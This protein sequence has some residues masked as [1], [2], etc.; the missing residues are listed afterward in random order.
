PIPK[1]ARACGGLE[2]TSESMR[3]LASLCFL[4]CFLP[5]KFAA[6]HDPECGELQNQ[7][8]MSLVDRSG[9]GDSQHRGD[10]QHQEHG[11]RDLV[12][13]PH[14]GVEHGLGPSYSCCD[15]A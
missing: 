13:R 6:A 8:T 5:L 4:V 1:F 9:G 3:T 12:E 15:A 11:K 2:R 10:G 14:D 7:H